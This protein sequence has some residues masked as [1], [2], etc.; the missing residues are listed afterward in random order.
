MYIQASTNTRLISILKNQGHEIG[1]IF[2]QAQTQDSGQFKSQFSKLRSGPWEV[3]LSKHKHK[4]Q[5]RGKILSH[6]HIVF[7]LNSQNE[8]YDLGSISK[9]AQTQ[10]SGQGKNIEARPHGI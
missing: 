2:K 1:S 3:Y 10:N 5:G 7:N 8:G 6:D 9:K 4:T